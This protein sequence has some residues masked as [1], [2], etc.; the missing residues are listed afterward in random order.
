MSADYDRDW[1][2]LEVPGGRVFHVACEDELDVMTRRLDKIADHYQVTR[3]QILANMRVTSWLNEDE[4]VL[5]TV[6]R[7]TDTLKP[8]SVLERLAA[9]AQ[10]FKPDLMVLDT[11]ADMFGGSENSR[12][13]TR[14]FLTAMRKLALSANPDAAVLMIA[15]PSLEGIRSG[16]G[17]S[18][19][20]AWHN[21]VRARCV[22]KKYKEPDSGD[23][24]DPGEPTLG[25]DMRMLEFRKNNYGPPQSSIPLMWKDGVFVA[26]TSQ[27]NTTLEHRLYE[28]NIEA[29]FLKVLRRR[30]MQDRPVSDRS[31]PN[32]A[33][34]EL[35]AEPEV[36]EIKPRITARQFADAM[37]RL[38][39]ADRLMVVSDGPK[40]RPGRTIVEKNKPV[41]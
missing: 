21:S 29:L 10:S 15:H 19:S 31:G 38:F 3:E 14:Q 39:A 25:S 41:E 36:R 9:E 40:W 30:N 23:N 26:Q 22:L 17:L 5:M 18:G 11:A 7:K 2:G 28:H 4:T 33:P 16:S 20:T 34:K 6:D 27:G 12:P 8:T 1:L 24:E 32:Y 37:K 35:A 13:H